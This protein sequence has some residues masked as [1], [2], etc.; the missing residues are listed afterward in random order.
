MEFPVLAAWCERSIVNLIRGEPVS[1]AFMLVHFLFLAYAI[2]AI[3]G[4]PTAGRIWQTLCSAGIPRHA[5]SRDRWISGMKTFHEADT[6][7]ESPGVLIY[8]QGI[9]DTAS[10]SSTQRSGCLDVGARRLVPELLETVNARGQRKP[11]NQGCVE[12]ENRA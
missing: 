4:T 11:V 12:D 7:R 1:A 9:S 5:R 6:F 8:K 10:L 2:G 3:S